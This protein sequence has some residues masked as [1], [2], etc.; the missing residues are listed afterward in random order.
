MSKRCDCNVQLAIIVS[1]PRRNAQ[2]HD[3]LPNRNQAWLE[4]NVLGFLRVS[5]FPMACRSKR[6]RKSGT[7]A[8]GSFHGSAALSSVASFSIA[9][10]GSY[11]GGRDRIETYRCIAGPRGAGV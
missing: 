4:M 5:H 7:H 8:A 10:S 11:C 3:Q 1:A 9:D 6:Q 2:G